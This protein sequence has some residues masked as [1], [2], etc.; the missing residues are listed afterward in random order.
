[1]SFP[2]IPVGKEL[3]AA[4]VSALDQRRLEK[5]RERKKSSA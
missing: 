5:E 1:M 2:K 4:G 3:G